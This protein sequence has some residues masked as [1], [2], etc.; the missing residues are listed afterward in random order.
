MYLYTL[1]FITLLLSLTSPLLPAF[2]SFFLSLSLN[3]SWYRPLLSQEALEVS[4]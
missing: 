1:S 2:L 3:H 4:I